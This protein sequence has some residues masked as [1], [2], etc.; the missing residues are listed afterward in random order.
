M[1]RLKPVGHDDRLSVVEHLDE[2]RSRLM[3]S[4]AVFFV[5]FV[6]CFWQD[7]RILGF[8]NA[9]LG[10]I[11]PVSLG[12]AEQFTTTLTV[13]AYAALLVSMPVLLYQFYA[14]ILPAFSPHERRVATPLLLMIP[15]L[16]IAGAAFG[17]FVVLPP[18]ITFLLGFNAEEFNTLVRAR[19][20]YSFAAMSLLATGVLFQIPVAVLALTRL[21]IVSVAKLRK[22]RRYAILG[23]AVVAALLPSVDPVTMILTMLPL[24]VLYEGSILL[25]AAVGS[26]PAETAE[27]MA[28]GS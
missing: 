24:V 20:Y 6:C 21:G 23:I 2:L 7:E 9:P 18:A 16:F 28:E 11:K 25:A 22:N 12:V 3:V 27:P 4:G 15:V 13:V 17:Y 5:A 8:A 10:G 19:E 1:A 14:F 26:P